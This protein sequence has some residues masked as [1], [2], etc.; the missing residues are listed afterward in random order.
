MKTRILILA[1]LAGTAACGTQ[2][3]DVVA[4]DEGKVCAFSAES[5]TGS[6]QSFLPN[7]AVYFRVTYDECLSACI[8]N[9]V[10]TCAVERNGDKLVVSSDFS[11]SEPSGSEPCILICYTLAASCKTEPLEAGT[12]QVE[13]GDN[14]YPLS[15]PA[16]DV[17]P[18]F[19]PTP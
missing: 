16:T 2:Q 14:A 1:L 13:H 7:E 17:D 15:I 4:T 3:P 9:E 18:C 8:N 12:Y 10:A 5:A 19:E 11:Y 6:E